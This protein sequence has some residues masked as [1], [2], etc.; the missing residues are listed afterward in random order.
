MLASATVADKQIAVA[1]TERYRFRFSIVV[2]CAVS[3]LLEV[4]FRLKCVVR[5]FFGLELL[6]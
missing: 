5:V 4:S 2:G 6:Q 1:N 3:L